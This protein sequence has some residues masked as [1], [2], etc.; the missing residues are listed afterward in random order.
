M[1]SNEL[2]IVQAAVISRREMAF[3]AAL[4]LAGLTPRSAFA[5]DDALTVMENDPKFKTW[6]RIIN[7]AGLEGYPREEGT[8]HTIF[9]PVEASFANISADSLKAILPT[10]IDGGADTSE[11]VYVVRSHVVDGLHPRSEFKN[12]IITLKSLN[13][14]PIIVDAN[15]PDKILIK[16]QTS[17][18]Y[19]S[20]QVIQ[21]SN[22]LIYPVTL[23]EA[24]YQQH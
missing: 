7:A 8:S 11:T 16:F 24:H 6:V 21:S 10:A 18:G 20:G 13:G 1:K 17:S 2:E 5:A 9:A 22:A 3:G 19:L 4:L 14:F 12:G 15:N 23:T